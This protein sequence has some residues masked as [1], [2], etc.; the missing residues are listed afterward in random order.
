MESLP[1]D[2]AAADAT[3]GEVPSEVIS[4]EMAAAAADIA[5]AAASAAA[6]SCEQPAAVTEGGTV[7][8]GHA[9]FTTEQT[10]ETSTSFHE[11]DMP[12]DVEV[13]PSAASTT[14]N[15]A[16]TVVDEVYAAMVAA[17]EN[18]AEAAAV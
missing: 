10:V 15:T 11:S 5:A 1:T 4:S 14:A 2:A 17:A 13:K 9:E 6:V 18:V 3:H 8:R 12:Y 16:T 7:S